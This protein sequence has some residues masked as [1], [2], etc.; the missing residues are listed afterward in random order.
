MYFILTSL[1]LIIII[2]LLIFQI[3]LILGAPF[4]EYAWGG[5]HKVLPRSLRIGSFVS[6]FIY[7]FI[8]L[9]TMNK[10]G[11]SDLF[12]QTLV[13]NVFVGIT[14]FFGLGV[15]LNGISRSKKER[16]LFTP[17]VFILFICCLIINM[18]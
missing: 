16:N 1:I 7:S 13:D 5:Q 15:I 14:V 12:N 18:S 9:I 10:V 8:G 2:L 3:S 17:V 4:G 6:L 11:W